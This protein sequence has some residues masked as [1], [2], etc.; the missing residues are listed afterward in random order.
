MKRTAAFVAVLAANAACGNEG[1]LVGPSVKWDLLWS[2]EFDG[3]AG[4]GPRIDSWQ[5]DVGGDG[6]G[7][8][9]LEYDT[10]HLDNACHDGYG[11]LVIT[12]REESFGDR[13]YTSARIKT[14]DR[15]EQRYGLFEARIQLPRGQGI[16]PAF[17][18]L[19]A[20]FEES[21]WP[22]CGEIDVMEYRGQDPA[23]VV[24][25]AHGPGYSGAEPISTT[26]RLPDGVGFD[27]GYHTFAVEWDPARIS[28][29]VDGEVYQIATTREVLERG[30]WVFDQPF[31]LLLNI[32]VGGSF[33]GA[34]DA[35]TVFPQAMRVDYVRV[36]ARRP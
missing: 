15:F 9:Q 5:F 36:F 13:A 3:V 24:G 18:M 7:N 6:W 35:S 14:M 23:V 34:P 28:W 25:S 11:N 29:S 20:N 12:A 2:D 19:G 22:E 27:D 21:G 4:T 33:V 16:W 26:Y 17:W 31:F 30:E 32:A 8:D 10:D 1:G